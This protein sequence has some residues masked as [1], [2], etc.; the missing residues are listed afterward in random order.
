MRKIELYFYGYTWEEYAFQISNVQGI[1]VIYKGRIDAD[2]LI[3]IKEILYIG[4]HKS[5][6]DL[7]EQNV[8]EFVK[9]YLAPTDRIFFSYAE[10]RS[11]VFGKDVA[12]LIINEVN[13]IY[14]NK[15]ISKITGYDLSCKGEYKLIPKRIIV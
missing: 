1:Y 4:Y 10:V 6:I 2:G 3:E 7:Y 12:A 15:N 13:P 14:N 9:E 8:I 5:F 11:E